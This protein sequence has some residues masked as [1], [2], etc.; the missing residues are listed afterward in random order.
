M[1]DQALLERALR[2]DEPAR[3]ELISVLQN[4]LDNG[5]VSPEAATIIDQRIVEADT[6][7]DDF[8]PVDEFE[9]EVRTRRSA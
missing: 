2:L 6:N 9:R 7:P 4:S 1:V 3:R 8:V 5:E